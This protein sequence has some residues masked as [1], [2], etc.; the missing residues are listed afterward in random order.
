MIDTATDR[1]RNQYPNVQANAALVVV[2]EEAAAV[3]KELARSILNPS[4]VKA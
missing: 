3:G 4:R 2:K 1:Y